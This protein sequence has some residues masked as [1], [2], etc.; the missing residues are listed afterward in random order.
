MRTPPQSW[1]RLS[2]YALTVIGILILGYCVTVF[3]EARYFEAKAARDFTAAL[4]H[5]TAAPAAPPANGSVIGQLQ[6]PRLEL[7]VMVVEGV[8]DGDLKLAAGHIPGTALPGQPGNVGI[9]AHR[10]TFFRP[11]RNIRRNDAILLSTLQG[12]YSY[13]VVSTAVVRPEDTQVLNP[14][15]HDRLTLVTCYPFNYVGS[16]PKRF[17]VWA[18]RIPGT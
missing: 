5:K 12:A 9:A 10:D 17:I 4:E 14:I 6:V 1:L 8:S 11:L 3:L 16:A 13:R 15:G 18:D 7:S 2:Q